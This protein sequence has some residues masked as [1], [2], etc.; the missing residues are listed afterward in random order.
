VANRLAGLGRQLYAELFL[1]EMR[2]A[3]RR[4]CKQVKILQITSDEPWF[5][6]EIVK[7]YDDSDPTDVLDHDFLCAQFQM[8]RWLAGPSCPQGRIHVQRL[9]C[10]EAAAA[11]GQNSLPFA[12]EE[13]KYI[14]SLA[15]S[16]PEDASP[17]PADLA[18]IE[19]LL[20]EGGIGLWH[21]AT[22]GKVD[23]SHPEDAAIILA[24]GRQLRAEDLHGPRQTL[25]ARDRPL[26]F[27]NACRVG[28]QGF[29][30]TRLAG[31]AAAWVQ[32]SRC[33]AFIGPLWAVDDQLA[34]RFAQSFYD[35]LKENTTIGQALAT[36][37]RQVRDLD[38]EIPTW[39]AYSVYAH[40]NARVA[41]EP[42]G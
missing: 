15:Q 36:A 26:V 22:H 14:A 3:Y 11:P 37:R 31:W 8:T 28:Q 25:I 19:A 17:C 42:L 18:S 13:R 33:G 38:A 39:L 12:T 4:F 30:L 2:A 32:R 41:L 7:P 10:I 40:P 29:S 35:A 6:W 16:G 9:A 34:F 21:F 24:D 20:D 27:L 5:P 23:P 1:P